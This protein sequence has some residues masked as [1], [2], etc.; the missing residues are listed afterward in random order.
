MLIIPVFAL[1]KCFPKLRAW[2]TPVGLGIMCLSLG[3]GS[4]STTVTHL[5]VTQGIFY[6]IGGALAWTPILF[7]IEEWWVRRRGFAYGVTMAGLGLSA[8]IL[9]VGKPGSNMGAWSQSP[10]LFCLNMNCY[11]GSTSRTRRRERNFREDV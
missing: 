1:L 3:L 9:P 2:A 7:Y 6:A 11:L 10:R 8:S 4:F 5:I